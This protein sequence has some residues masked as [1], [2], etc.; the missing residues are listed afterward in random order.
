[1]SHDEQV[2]A[3]NPNQAE[4]RFGRAI[5]LVQLGRDREA[6]DRL[7]ADV[8]AFPDQSLFPHAL[9][10]LLA[11]AS[12]D[13]VRDG[14]RALA[15]VG[16]LLKSE[17]RTLELGETMAMALAAATRYEDAARVQRDLV[18]GAE[19]SGLQRVVPRLAAN[20]ALYERRQP[21]RTPWPAGE[22]P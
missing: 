21:C 4:A 8:K 2:L 6:R 15:L 9:A 20:L 11:A 13:R 17:Q 12:D 3:E 22:I 16:Q 18:R 19:G 1:M 10:R 14:E 5:A 7:V